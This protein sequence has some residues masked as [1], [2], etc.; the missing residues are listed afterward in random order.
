MPNYLNKAAIL[1][2]NDDAY[3]DVPVPEW[4]GIVRV[5]RLSAAEKD[6][7]EAS[8]VE[9]RQERGRVVERPNLVNMRAK[10]A[11]RCI[12]NPDGSLVFDE[13]DIPDLGRKSGA[14]LDRVV[15]S[16]K[17]LNR[18]TD[19]DLQEMVQSLKNDPPVALPTG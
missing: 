7:F 2:A 5:R 4:G 17:R 8:I 10:L 14:A 15:A 18:M 6:A 13:A 3:E 16:A 11:A 12:V 19:A 1:A 9:I